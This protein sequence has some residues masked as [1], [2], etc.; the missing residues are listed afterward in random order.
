MRGSAA[1]RRVAAR[2]RSEAQQHG[3]ALARSGDPIHLAGCM[4]FWAEGSKDRNVVD[5]TN[6]DPDMVHLFLQFLRRSFGV[7]DD[8]LRLLLN[9]YV[10][11]GLTLEEVED[12]WLRRLDIPR[13]CLRKHTV[14]K[15]SRVSSRKRRTLLYGTAR[16]R[17]C[18]TFI[19]QSIYGSIQEFAGIQ[20]PEWLDCGLLT[21]ETARRE[22]GGA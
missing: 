1:N 18:S 22:M 5:F 15:N 21:D 19:V 3:R 13:S 14:N 2:K 4:L 16:L 6:S 17:V 11:Q 10:G 8:Q 7:T 9:C 20:R 12:W